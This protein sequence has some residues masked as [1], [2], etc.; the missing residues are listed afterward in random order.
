M[1]LVMPVILIFYNANN[2]S[3][4]HLFYI[5]AAYSL[6]IVLFELPTGYLADIWGRKN[7][8][9]VGAF[10]GFAGYM[11]YSLTS[12]FIYFLIA[13]VML[14][15]GQSFMSGTDTA[16]LYDTMIGLKKEDQYLKVEG[17][18]TSVG[19]FAEAISGILGGLLA[20]YSPRLP[21]ICQACFA[22]VAIPAA[23]TLVEPK[24]SLAQHKPLF[25]DLLIAYRNAL[26]KNKA[27][28]RNLFIS[29]IIG[30]S[31]LT[32][33]WFV[34][35]YF[36]TINLPIALYG[37]CWSVLNASVGIAALSAFRFERWFG[38]NK[39]IVG[40]VFL[41]TL[42]YLSLFAFQAYWALCFI[43][44]FYLVRGIATPLL[45]DSINRLISSDTRASIL[46][47]R[48]LIIRGI[49]STVAPIA[50]WIADKIELP[51]ALLFAGSTFFI[52][53]LPFVFIIMFS[54]KK[55]IHF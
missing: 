28:Q 55:Q 27:L 14:G 1:L 45:K 7:T 40:I 2:L 33:A 10:F 15:I 6:T 50:G 52:L 21:F 43:L 22:L 31:T 53:C 12:G 25:N 20:V 35:P 26:F 5:Q 23:L 36:K 38:E 11:M 19:N 4:R 32:M 8:L 16:M 17:R 24:I 51:T 29:S 34:Q 9:V 13:E 30:A 37:V 48:N 54:R 41:T 42:G 18:M 39:M 44:L 46:S 47:L 49:F 3:T